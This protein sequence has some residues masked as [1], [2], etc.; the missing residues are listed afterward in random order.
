VVLQEARK[1]TRGES[2]LHMMTALPR[3]G[4]AA[5]VL[6]VSEEFHRIGS[7]LAALRGAFLLRPVLSRDQNGQLMLRRQQLL[8]L[9]VP[10]FAC[11]VWSRPLGA[12]VRLGS[13]NIKA[14]ACPF[15]Q[16]QEIN[17]RHRALEIRTALHIREPNFEE[18]CAEAFAIVRP[19]VYGM[20]SQDRLKP[21]IYKAT[22]RSL[23]HYEQG[24]NKG[25]C[26]KFGVHSLEAG[27]LG[28]GVPTNQ[29]LQIGN[30]KS[31]NPTRLEHMEAFAQELHRLVE[32]KM[33][34]AV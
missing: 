3:P 25:V 23:P 5:P 11:F 30:C 18:P 32:V 31:Q 13:L 17:V 7:I 34:K 20:L 8:D 15:G 33:L 27:F 19:A 9:V 16:I 14:L 4:R 29:Q 28:F 2:G 26:G 22:R 24:T 6:H 1:V 10:S 21:S 12:D